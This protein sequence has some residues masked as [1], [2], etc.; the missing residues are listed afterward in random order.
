MDKKRKTGL[1]VLTVG[2]GLVVGGLILRTTVNNIVK[3]SVEKGL[4][5]QIE[6]QMGGEA[7]VDIDLDKEEGSLTITSDDEKVEYTT[8]GELP[9]NFPGDLETYPGAEIQGSYKVEEEE[10]QGFSVAML[11]Q[12][13]PQTVY[14]FYIDSLDQNGWTI[15]G[16]LETQD[17]YS[18][19]ASK[20]TRSVVV[21]IGKGDEGTAITI[22]LVLE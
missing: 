19:I 13:N 5:G 2:V 15:S 22:T 4:E 14:N 6:Q 7:N 3:K 8:T 1:I 21:G 10:G 18:A 17:T 12:D 20:D 9:E 16:K 11:T